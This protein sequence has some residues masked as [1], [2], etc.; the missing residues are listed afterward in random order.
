M[1]FCGNVVLMSDV[2][3]WLNSLGLEQYADS[4]VAGDIEWEI[5][6]QLDHEVLR[7]LGVSSPGHRLKI[8]KAAGSL[9]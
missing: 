9:S 5:L 6:P 1:S 8:L 7:E 2:R 4:F 3:E